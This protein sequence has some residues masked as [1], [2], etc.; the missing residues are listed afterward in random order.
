MEEAPFPPRSWLDVA[1]YPDD[2]VVSGYREHRMD[3]PP[4][5]P[6]RAP[7]YRWGWANARRDRSGSIDDGYDQVRG[8]YIAACKARH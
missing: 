6:N 4:P 2:D 5:G 3:D 8:D 1:A 7:G